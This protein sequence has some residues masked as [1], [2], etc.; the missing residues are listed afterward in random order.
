MSS[1]NITGSSLEEITKE[2][3][4]PLKVTLTVDNN[5][6]L[7]TISVGYENSFPVIARYTRI[8]DNLEAEIVALL[9]RYDIQDNNKKMTSRALKDG[10]AKV[11]K[12]ERKQSTKTTKVKFSKGLL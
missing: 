9:A 5:S 12:V 10:T 8:P 6:N 11:K 4:F 7:Y 2:C 1:V 3:K